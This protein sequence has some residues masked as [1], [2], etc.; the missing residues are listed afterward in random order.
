MFFLASRDDD[1][2]IIPQRKLSSLELIDGP[3]LYSDNQKEKDA[4]IYWCGSLIDILFFFKNLV[5]ILIRRVSLVCNFQGSMITDFPLLYFLGVFVLVGMTTLLPWNFFIS[6]T[7][8]WDYK[9][10]NVSETLKTNGSTAKTDLQKEFTSYLS[11]S[12]TVPNATF[13]II[14]ALGT[15][16]ILRKDVYSTKLNLTS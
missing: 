15:I 1:N 10:R 12:S 7:N 2:S 11:I 13:V 14:N 5:C 4:Y 8:F 3:T 6:L 9:F 16:H